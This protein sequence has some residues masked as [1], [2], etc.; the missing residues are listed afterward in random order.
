VPVF[1]ETE[2]KRRQQRFGGG[3]KWMGGTQGTVLKECGERKESRRS[4]RMMYRW[5][6][7]KTQSTRIFREGEWK[8]AFNLRVTKLG[9][10]AQS[11]GERGG[12][13]ICDVSPRKTRNVAVKKGLFKLW[14]REGKVKMFK[15]RMG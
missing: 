15:A 2:G 7:E 10:T 12:Q 9:K 6:G 14:G 4:R 3:L 11:G 1:I 5:G 13:P 8:E